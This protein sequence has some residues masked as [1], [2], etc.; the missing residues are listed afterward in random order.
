MDLF[1]ELAIRG[2]EFS[3]DG[4]GQTKARWNEARR[5]LQNDFPMYT[6]SNLSSSRPRGLAILI[7]VTA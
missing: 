5:G 6:E 1:N 4:D 7:L 2:S 3:L